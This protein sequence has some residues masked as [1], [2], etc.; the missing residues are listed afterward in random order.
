[1]LLRELGMIQSKTHQSASFKNAA[2]SIASNSI[3][4][5]SSVTEKNSLTEHLNNIERIHDV[6][7]LRIIY[8]W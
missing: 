7:I 2:V 5:L 1:M 6:D 3:V 8:W 4:P